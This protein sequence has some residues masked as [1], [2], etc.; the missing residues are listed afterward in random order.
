M[1]WAKHGWASLGALV[2]FT[3]LT[4]LGGAWSPAAW[5]TLLGLATLTSILYLHYK[6]RSSR[7]AEVRKM[8]PLSPVRDDRVIPEEVKTE[9]A[10][11]DKG[12]C[13][14]KGPKCTGG[15]TVWDHKVPWAWGGTSKDA[16]NI[17]QACRACNSWKS[18]SFA[19]TP[20]GRITY[21]EWKR[22][23]AA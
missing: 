15:G 22:A 2:T 17:Q 14:I 11:R 12:V 16:A 21:E 20:G 6:R 19:D 3:V 23:R 7:R 18:D 13:Q 9:V 5:Y 1:T 10:L 4:L 8:T